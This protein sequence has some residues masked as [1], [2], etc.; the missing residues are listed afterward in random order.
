MFLCLIKNLAFTETNGK[1][2][3]DKEGLVLLVQIQYLIQYLGT[4]FRVFIRH[5][6]LKNSPFTTLN[7]PTNVQ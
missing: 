2:M 3:S 4:S 1:S 6:S 7:S 5:W